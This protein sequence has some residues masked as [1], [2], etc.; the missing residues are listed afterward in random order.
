MGGKPQQVNSAQASQANAAAQ[1]SEKASAALTQQ[2]T[3]Q[4]GQNYN[5]LFGEDGKSGSLTPFM[6]S[7][8]VT[9][10]AGAPTGTYGTIYNNAVQQGGRDYANARGSLA[11]QWANRGT[12]AGMPNGFQADQERKLGSSAAD[13]NGQNF[14]DLASKAHSEDVNNFWN[15]TNTAAGQQATSTGAAVS[16]AANEGNTAGNIYSTAGRQATVNN[17]L[18]SA[19][20]A[21]GTVGA[22]AMCP[23][24]GGKIRT[25]NGDVAIEHLSAGDDLL[26][27]DGHFRPLPEDPY[28]VMA[29]CVEIE[30][31]R[32]R[33][34]RVSE[35][36]AFSTNGGGYVDAIVSRNQEIR[37]HHEKDLVANVTKCGRH[38]VFVMPKFGNNTYLCDGLWSLT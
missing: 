9:N 18:N 1:E 34:T 27:S 26:Q 8:K 12:A 29:E 21:G 5:Y 19:I 14:T 10:G 7:G 3:K 31:T 23:A 4:A 32:D 6:D 38:E 20:S 11:Q 37:A 15:A 2:N 22:A 28:L 16:S 24:R 35:G 17:P 25:K 13:A 30:T 33:K 36:H